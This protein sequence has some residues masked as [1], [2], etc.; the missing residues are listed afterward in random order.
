MSGLK[1]SALPVVRC[2][3]RADGSS[4]Q[5]FP[6][7]VPEGAY[8]CEL[9]EASCRSSQELAS[10]CRSAG[11]KAKVRGEHH[12]RDNQ[13]ATTQKRGR[14]LQL[15]CFCGRVRSCSFRRASPGV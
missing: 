12:K 14:K 13:S 3:A 15:V 9:C 2:I 5:L 4:A 1:Q 6:L 7:R 10:H 11:R 8:R